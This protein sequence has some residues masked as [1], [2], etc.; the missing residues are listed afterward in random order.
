MKANRKFFTLTPLCALLLAAGSMAIWNNPWIAFA[1]VV[2]SIPIPWIAVIGAND[3]PPLP[4]AQ[5]NRYVAGALPRQTS[6]ALPPGVTGA[7][8]RGPGPRGTGDGEPDP[9][10]S[11]GHATGPAPGPTATPSTPP[12]PDE[13]DPTP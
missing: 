8:T 10:E 6:Y 7:P 9:T 11:P 2:G 12:R 3:R 1:I 13:S 4:K 5:Q